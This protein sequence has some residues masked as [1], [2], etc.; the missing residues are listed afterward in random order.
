LYA[1]TTVT[2]LSSLA[3]LRKKDARTKEI[4]IMTIFK[5]EER[6]DFVAALLQ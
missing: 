6:K 3:Y 1:P 2:I 5:S 4:L